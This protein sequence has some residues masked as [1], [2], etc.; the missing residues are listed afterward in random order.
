MLMKFRVNLGLF[1]GAVWKNWPPVELIKQ[2][3][4]GSIPPE[5]LIAVNCVQL[6]TVASFS[7]FL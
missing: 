7:L 4:R 1:Q 2:A 6:T 3:N 5:L